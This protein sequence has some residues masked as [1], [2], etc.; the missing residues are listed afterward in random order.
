M[1]LKLSHL[2]VDFRN[3]SC[4]ISLFLQQTSLKFCHYSFK[5]IAY[6]KPLKEIKKLPERILSVSF[7][8]TIRLKN[9]FF[10]RLLYQGKHSAKAKNHTGVAIK[11]I[12]VSSS[13][14]NKY[15]AKAKN[16]IQM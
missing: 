16:A 10:K 12:K 4:L 11:P 15:K 8:I 2:S 13:W 3:L 1:R 9:Y 6:S 5:F 14:L 7:L